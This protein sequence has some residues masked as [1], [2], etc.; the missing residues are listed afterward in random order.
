MR[1]LIRR[2]TTENPWRARRIQAKEVLHVN[3]TAHLT[4]AWVIQP[5]REAFPDETSIRFQ[6]PDNDTIFSDRV[7]DWVE[8]LRIEPKA[9]ACRSPWQN[10]LAERSVGAVRRE[11]PDHVIV[12]DEVHLRRLLLEFVVYSESEQVHTRLGDSPLG[13]PAEER[14]S[15]RAQVVGRPR[16]GGLSSICVE[17][18]CMTTAAALQTFDAADADEY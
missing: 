1:E 14:P 4:S 9:T 3:V 6:I 11:L 7:A 8:R 10:G 17:P 12:I 16:P 13:R 18:R 5:L 15:S 2:M